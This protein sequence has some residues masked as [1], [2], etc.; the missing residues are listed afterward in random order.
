MQQARY[1]FVSLRD[2]LLHH[3]MIA[4]LF[5]LSGQAYPCVILENEHDCAK[6]AYLQRQGPRACSQIRNQS[7]QTRP[8]R[9]AGAWRSLRALGLQEPGPA[10]CRQASQSQRAA[11]CYISALGDATMQRTGSISRNGRVR[12]A[13]V[14]ASATCRRSESLLRRCR[15]RLTKNVNHVPARVTPHSVLSR[16]GACQTVRSDVTR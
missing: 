6:K 2:K 3:L 13:Q 16:A 15:R 8:R 4:I 9:A 12:D 10:L 14:V 7:H 5:H 11:Q 1:V